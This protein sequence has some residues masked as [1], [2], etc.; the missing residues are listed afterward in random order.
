L[1]LR[2]PLFATPELKAV[3]DE[4]EYSLSRVQENI[5]RGGEIVRG[6][7]TYTRK[8]EEGF[9][10]CS[11]DD[12]V[13]TAYEMA[14]FKIRSADF[15]ILKEY[16]PL[17][18]PK[19]KGNFTQLQEVFFNLIDNAYDATVQ[20]KAELKEE[21]YVGAVRI[22]VKEV[23][24]LVE[25]VVSDNGIGVKSIDKDKLFTPFFTTKAT[26]K[27]G[28][29]L[30]LYV[31]RKIV[32]DNHGGRVEMHSVHGEGTRMVLRLALSRE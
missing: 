25:I 23:D 8:G 17:M 14:Q 28:T 22:N 7:M 6:L 30:G 9:G 20:R 15:K 29:G 1:K 26:S 32:E 31:I 12:I 16:D 27:K 21:E 10:P 5:G 24:G 13:R 11:I 18:I 3:G 4:F 19:V 2:K